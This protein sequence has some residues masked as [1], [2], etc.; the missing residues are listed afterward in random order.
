LDNNENRI[1]PQYHF[2]QTVAGLDA[3]NVVRLIK[4][5]KDFPVRLVN[6]RSFKELQENHW[7]AHGS[8]KPTPQSILEHL[9]LIQSC[10]VRFA[11]ILDKQGRVMDG[12][13]RICKAILDQLAVIPAVQFT[14]DPEP[15]H[16]NCNPT[17]LPYDD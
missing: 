10:D 11:I 2:R 12:M 4:L 6:P 15:D 9:Q 16:T 7:Y 3:W 5:S 8:T 1:R 17:E 14:L 13:H